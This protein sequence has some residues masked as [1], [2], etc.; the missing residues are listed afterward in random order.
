MGFFGFI[1]WFPSSRSTAWQGNFN[2]RMIELELSH[3][4]GHPAD[5]TV[6]SSAC[7]FWSRSRGL[8][9]IERIQDGFIIQ[10][11]IQ[12]SEHIQDGFTIRALIYMEK[13][14]IWREINRISFSVVTP[15]FLWCLRPLPPRHEPTSHRPDSS[16]PKYCNVKSFEIVIIPLKFSVTRLKMDLYYV[17]MFA[18]SLG[19]VPYRIFSGKSDFTL[20]R[21]AR[22][23]AMRTRDRDREERQPC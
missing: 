10:G 18:E 5:H 12:L 13:L 8:Q 15:S 2:G 11:T 17:A 22:F 19:L 20:G 3:Q 9:L 14:K 7:L 6:K 21:F 4:P 16:L 1:I 23:T